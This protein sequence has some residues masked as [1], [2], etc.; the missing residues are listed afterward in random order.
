[1]IEKMGQCALK[2]VINVCKIMKKYEEKY[3]E[4]CRWQGL[5][6]SNREQ[7]LHINLSQPIRFWYVLHI[8]LATLPL[9]IF[10]QV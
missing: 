7:W 3:I 6:K 9:C 8:P 10:A 1:M 2:S 5:S 4:V